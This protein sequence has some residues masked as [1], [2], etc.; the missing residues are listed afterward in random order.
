MIS[1]IISNK[2]H[3][4]FMLE[5]INYLVFIYNDIS[6]K[7]RQ[8]M[9][10][11]SVVFGNFGLC[12]TVFYQVRYGAVHTFSHTFNFRIELKCN[13]PDFKLYPSNFN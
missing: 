6:A 7:A 11:S 10:T 2:F 1:F 13:P 12:G 8:Q 5:K 4:L 9:E 3:N